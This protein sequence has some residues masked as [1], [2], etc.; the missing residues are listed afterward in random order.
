MNGKTVKRKPVQ[1]RAEF[2]SVV[3]GLLVRIF[4][5][6]E[7]DSLLNNNRSPQK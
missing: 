1:S 3:H 7:S 5:V 2:V 6:C 4:C